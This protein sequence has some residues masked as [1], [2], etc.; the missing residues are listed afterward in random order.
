MPVISPASVQR[1]DDIRHA[2]TSD[3]VIYVAHGR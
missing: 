3:N 2:W 1:E